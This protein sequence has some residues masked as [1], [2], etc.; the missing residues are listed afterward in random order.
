MPVMAHLEQRNLTF[1]FLQPKDIA[2]AR[3]IEKIRERLR[4]LKLLA[5]LREVHEYAT[6][7]GGQDVGRHEVTISTELVTLT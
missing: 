1:D 2:T 6:S 4:R 7:F 3:L 5:A